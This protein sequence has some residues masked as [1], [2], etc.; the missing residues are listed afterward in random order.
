MQMNSE[1]SYALKRAEEEAIIAINSDNTA[2]AAIHRRL[3]ALYSARALVNL[4]DG[5]PSA[6][7][8]A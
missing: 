5:V 7:R 4:V 8:P 2:A 1:L 3:S 6:R